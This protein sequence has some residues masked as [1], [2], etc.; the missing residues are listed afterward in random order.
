MNKQV[1]YSWLKVFTVAFMTVFLADVADGGFHGLQWEAMAIAGTLS[2]GPV[3][4]N[5]LDPNDP[6]YGRGSE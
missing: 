2:V 4:I 3:V 6:R 1:A 5:W